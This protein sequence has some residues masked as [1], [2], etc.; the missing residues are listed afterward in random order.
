MGKKK[1]ISRKELLN[2]Q[3]EFLTYSAKLLQYAAQH[4]KRLAV[5]L[6]VLF[7][8]GI[9]VS[10][11]QYFSAQNE[12]KAFA[13]VA[14]HHQRYETLASQQAGAEAYRA[15]EKDFKAIIDDYSGT[16][17][18]RIAAVM[19]ANIS[20]QGGDYDTAI[21]LYRQNLKAFEHDPAI[22]SLMLSNLGYCR[23]AKKEYQAAAQYFDQIVQGNRFLMKDDALF[24][25]ARVY[26]AM[27]AKEKR[28]AALNRLVSDHKD[29]IYH[30]VA[31]ELVAGS[32]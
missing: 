29:S 28:L 31:R 24:S 25:L 21:A 18:A 2:Q 16:Q 27:G 19:L 30:D 22:Q 14:Q 8:V 10:G 26:D 23:E 1:K 6:G 11:Y 7:A 12:K 5:A 3:D 9:A 20:Y 13:L 17:A 4:K 32:S 15:V